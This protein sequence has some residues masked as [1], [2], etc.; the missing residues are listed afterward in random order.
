[1]TK[2]V[3]IEGLNQT[4]RTVKKL[5]VEAADLK[6]AFSRIGSR[7][8]S[9]VKSATPVGTGRLK[10]TVKQSRRQNS[11]YISA[12]SKRAYYGP[13]VHWGTHTI[14]GN[15]WMTRVANAEA[16]HA[17]DELQKE[18]DQIIRQLGLDS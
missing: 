4:V 14:K 7:A 9:K 8:T 16:P 6:D 10:A 12:G 5:G 17:L 2:T 15:P 3:T 18:L 11:V 13:F 1:M